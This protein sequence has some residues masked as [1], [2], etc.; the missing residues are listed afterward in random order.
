MT[1]GAGG[2]C[3]AAVTDRTR[4][5]WDKSTECGELLHRKRFLP[6]L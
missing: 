5:Q 6:R 2:G 1:G 4:C 3:E